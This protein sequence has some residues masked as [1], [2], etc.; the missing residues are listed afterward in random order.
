MTPTHE[1][2]AGDDEAQ[3]QRTH[4]VTF[5]RTRKPAPIR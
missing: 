4:A 3:L 2:D 1:Q 5:E